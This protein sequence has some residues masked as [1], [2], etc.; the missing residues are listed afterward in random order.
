[1]TLTELIVA[2]SALSASVTGGFAYFMRRLDSRKFE[3]EIIKVTAEAKRIEAEAE[4]IKAETK[5]L[6]SDR[7]LAEIN[8]LDERQVQMNRLNELQAQEI[9]QLR[10]DLLKYR[11]REAAH[12]VENA[13][14]RLRIAELESTSDQV[15]ADL[16][17]LLTSTFKPDIPHTSN[18]FDLSDE[19]E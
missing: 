9:E 4:K 7:L 1:M 17:R 14:L 10:N 18:E 2:S 5:D 13:T 19:Q 15:P 16:N 6:F 8:R 12:A 3:Q 11:E